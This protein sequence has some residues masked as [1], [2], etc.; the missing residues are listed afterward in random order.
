MPFEIVRN[1]IT[2]MQV[3]AIVNTANPKPKYSSG[4]DTAV[5]KAAG[6]EELLAEAQM[7]KE[8]KMA[9]IIKAKKKSFCETKARMRRLERKPPSCAIW[10]NSAPRRPHM[11]SNAIRITHIQSME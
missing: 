6:E 9:D 10:K 4:T 3:D 1:D 2:K 5:Y 7:L 11:P 8:E